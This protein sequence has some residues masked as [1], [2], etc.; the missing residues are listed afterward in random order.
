MCV[1]RIDVDEEPNGTGFFVA[2]GV[3]LTCRH[4]IENETDLSIIWQGDRHTVTQ[5]QIPNKD[6][7]LA[8]LSVNSPNHDWVFLDDD[9]TDFEQLKTFGFP[10]NYPQGDP[11]TLEFEGFTGG[12]L[13]LIKLKDGQVEPGYSGA[14][15][16]NA[17][18]KKVCGVVKSTRDEDYALGGRA[19]PVS[20]VWRL[21]PELK[22]TILEIPKNPFL[23]RSGRIDL[24]DQFF[25]REKELRSVFEILNSGSSVAIIG[26]RQVGK[27]SFLKAIA[28]HSKS[29]LNQYRRPVYLDCQSLID[30][31]DFYEEL[32]L[33]MDIENTKASNL[34]RALR[35]S[36]QSFLLLLDD[37][38]M[39][40]EENFSFQIRSQ[41]RA[42]SLGHDAPF[43]LVV[44]ASV[45]LDELF[46]DARGR[47][48]PLQNIC[49]NEFLAGWE[50][51]YVKHFVDKRLA[52][53]PIRFS[54]RDIIEIL[55]QTQGHPQKVMEACY[56]LYNRYKEDC[57]P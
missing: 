48:S 29:Q 46:P 47:V 31:A 16:V 45:N 20:L 17:R 54:E 25:G 13:S 2:Q 8:L 15:L 51:K 7:D 49:I 32:C 28:H 57:L 37:V 42:L 30:N 44:A 1:V 53:T 39:L 22:P 35:R 38:E 41:L 6:V 36:K 3:A 14:P 9:V 18:T 4:V 11:L 5:V 27:S 23:P 55:L 40:A 56:Q 21:F 43:K 50:E 34:K 12:S 10:K 33:L 52:A 26:E 24:P 19:V